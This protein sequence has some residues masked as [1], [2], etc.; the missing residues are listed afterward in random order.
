MPRE[1]NLEFE[2]KLVAFVAATY[3]ECPTLPKDRVAANADL[4]PPSVTRIFIGSLEKNYN[5]FDNLFR[6]TLL[7]IPIV[8]VSNHR[9]SRW[10]EKIANRSKRSIQQIF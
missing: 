4:L 10:L 6:I 8:L 9:Q 2:A 7:S 3:T 5:L 1:Q